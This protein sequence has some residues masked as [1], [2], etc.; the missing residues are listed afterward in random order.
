[1][2][3][4]IEPLFQMIK[5]SR[6]KDVGF[7]SSVLAYPPYNPLADFS[8]IATFILTNGLTKPI[9]NNICSWEMSSLPPE[10]ALPSSSPSPASPSQPLTLR[11]IHLKGK[12]NT[13]SCAPQLYLFAPGGLPWGSR[14]VSKAYLFSFCL[15][16][17]NFTAVLIWPRKLCQSASKLQRLYFRGHISITPGACA[18]QSLKSSGDTG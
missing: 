15:L 9:K 5:G 8:G 1:M 4:G 18:K 14:D 17:A 7:P 16:L 13:F 12:V 11:Y 2:Q 3:N 6:K 10:T